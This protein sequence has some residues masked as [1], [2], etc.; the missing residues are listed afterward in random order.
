[1]T[2]QCPECSDIYREHWLA[3]DGLLCRTCSAALRGACQF[4]DHPA[5]EARHP[6]SYRTERPGDPC[7]YCA[8]PVPAD[9]TPCPACWLSLENLALADI[10]AVFAG[11]GTFDIRPE[12]AP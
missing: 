9:G 3:S 6:C 2:F 8:R 11:D 7:R 5:H 12:V 10:K 4:E 1:M